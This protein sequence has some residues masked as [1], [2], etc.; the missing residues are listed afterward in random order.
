MRIV[1]IRASNEPILDI[2]A[3]WHLEL[4]LDL[5]VTAVAELGLAGFEQGLRTAAGMNAVARGAAHTIFA[6][7][8]A[9]KARVFAVMATLAKLIHLFL[10]S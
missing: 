2:V 8:G 6:V 1:A 10:S 9:V 7:R 3:R 5:R 4:R